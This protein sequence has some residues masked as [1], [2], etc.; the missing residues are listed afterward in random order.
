MNKDTA[1]EVLETIYNY[2]ILADQLDQ[3]RLREEMHDQ[4]Q[5]RAK[6][7][8]ETVNKFADLISFNT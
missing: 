3:A 4:L 2:I 8:Q 1:R 5:V 6:E 7:V